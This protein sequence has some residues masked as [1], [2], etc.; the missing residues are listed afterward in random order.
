MGCGMLGAG[1]IKFDLKHL[2]PST[3]HQTKKHNLLSKA[4]VFKKT[5]THFI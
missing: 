2:T 1:S 4:K 3:Q 5:I